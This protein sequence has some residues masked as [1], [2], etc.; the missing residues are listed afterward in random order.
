MAWSELSDRRC[1]SSVAVPRRVE[2]SR[3]IGKAARVVKPV[4]HKLK[5]VALV[6]CIALLGIC[7]FTSDL[8]QMRTK[9]PR[10]SDLVQVL[11]QAG[12]KSI[13]KRPVCRNCRAHE[14]AKRTQLR[15]GKGC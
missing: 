13:P 1:P 9:H 15:L 14:R 6:R 12:L 5:D 7:P 10:R 3:W 2:Q 11:K 8:T 4:T